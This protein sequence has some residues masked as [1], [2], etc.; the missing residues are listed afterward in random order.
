MPL[1]TQLQHGQLLYFAKGENDLSVYEN[2][3]FRWMAFGDVVQSVI[4]KQ[5]PHQLTLP[6]QWAMT[7]PLLTLTTYFPMHKVK[8]TSVPLL[9]LS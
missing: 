3:Y 4:R 2:K 8:I 9:S 1:S 5:K 6:H 7:M